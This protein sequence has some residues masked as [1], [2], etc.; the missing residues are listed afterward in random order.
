MTQHP[1]TEN[2]KGFFQNDRKLVCSMLVIYGL[3][4]FGAIAVTFWGLNR[5]QLTLS[6]NGTSTAGKCHGNGRCTRQG[7]G[8]I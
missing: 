3:C 8:A 7:A 4:I 2:Q 1:A 6:A 5:R